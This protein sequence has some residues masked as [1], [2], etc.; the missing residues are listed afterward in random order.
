MSVA[1]IAPDIWAYDPVS[2]VGLAVRH[3]EDG[4]HL[5]AFYAHRAGD[6]CAV[7]N[8]MIIA[9]RLLTFPHRQVVFHGWEADSA[10]KCETPSPWALAE[11][12][13]PE[14]PRR[15]SPSS[16]TLSFELSV[17]A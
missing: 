12:Y 9:R 1:A 11:A 17:A 5:V 15:P 10:P 4:E 3:Y 8:E 7:A 14:P 16:G 6:G 13:Q 2:R